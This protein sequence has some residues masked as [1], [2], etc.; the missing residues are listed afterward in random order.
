[1]D[2]MSFVFGVVATI[3]AEFIALIGICIWACIAKNKRK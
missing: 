1:M 2:V 3:A